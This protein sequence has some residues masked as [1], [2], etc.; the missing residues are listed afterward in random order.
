MPEV[1]ELAPVLAA[2]PMLPGP[3]W[4][5]A[6]DRVFDEGG[7]ISSSALIAPQA[8]AQEP[9]TDG[10]PS[11]DP[12]ALAGLAVAIWGT[13]EY[14]SRRSDRDRDRRRGTP[15]RSPLAVR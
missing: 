11:A 3:V 2:R 12:A 15:L 9:E 6:V 10:S 13:W 4:E 14:R 7:W 8:P 5:A 1:G